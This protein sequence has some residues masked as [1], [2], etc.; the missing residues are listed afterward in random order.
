M[1]WKGV[2]DEVVESKEKKKQKK[3]YFLAYLY[4]ASTCMKGH[5]VVSVLEPRTL[6]PALPDS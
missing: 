2:F 4:M 1:N 5:L 3:T 6:A